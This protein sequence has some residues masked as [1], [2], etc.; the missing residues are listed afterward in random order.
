M[1]STYTADKFRTFFVNN[2]IVDYDMDDGTAWFSPENGMQRCV[3][4]A[5]LHNNQQPSC[6]D[7]VNLVMAP[8]RPEARTELERIRPR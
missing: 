2:P 5:S 7:D 1:I 3:D 8:T 4:R 6:R